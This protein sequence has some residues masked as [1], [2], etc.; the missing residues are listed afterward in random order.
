MRET[1]QYN[2]DTI[3]SS[4]KYGNSFMYEQEQQTQKTQ[5]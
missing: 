5:N 2:S 3:L 4:R 1:K